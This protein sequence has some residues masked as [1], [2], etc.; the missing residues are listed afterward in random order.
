MTIN[1]SIARD[2]TTTPGARSMNDGMYSGEE[3]RV[4]YLE[5]Y[6]TD[7]S[8]DKIVID[9]DSVEGYST[10]FL[11][12][13]FGG[14]VRDFGKDVVK[15]RMEFISIEEPLLLTEILEY[16]EKAERKKL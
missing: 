3:F 14:L 15:K 2:F 12:E 10:A 4:N 16:I 8:T 13:V 1:I 6:F 9:L 7:G 5:K 11:E